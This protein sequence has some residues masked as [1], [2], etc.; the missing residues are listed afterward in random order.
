[1]RTTSKILAQTV[2]IAAAGWFAGCNDL[3]DNEPNVVLEV[4]TLTIP[5][6][7]AALTS[8]ICSFTITPASATFS[9]KPKNTKATTSPY[10]DIIMQDVVIGFEWDDGA[11]PPAPQTFG[12]PATIPAN[13]TGSAIFALVNAAVLTSAPNRDGNSA[14]MTML[15][16][17]VTVGGEAVS[18]TSYGTLQVNNCTTPPQGACCTLTTCTLLSQIDCQNISGAVYKGD[19]TTCLSGGACPP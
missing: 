16:R 7:T 19:G 15:F 1:M 2:L 12:V 5:P 8:G 6:V 18:V 9:N 4:Q 3:I 14:T 17:G 11:T 13:G 10:N